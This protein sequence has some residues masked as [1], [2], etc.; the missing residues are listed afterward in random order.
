MKYYAV[1]KGKTPGIYTSWNECKEQIS[2]F[3]DA[4]YKSFSTKKEAEAFVNEKEEELIKDPEAVAYVDGS[5]NQKDQIYGYGGFIIYKKEFPSGGKTETK[6]TLKGKGN[7][8]DML[9][10]RNVSGEILGTQAIV[11]KAIDM[12]IK[13]I[14]IYYDYKGIEMWAKGLWNRNKSGT[15]DYYN[16]MQS[17]KDKII[18]DFVKVKGHTGVA[19]NEEAD[20]LAKEAV[21]IK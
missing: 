2:G 3:P 16:Y 15:I 5:Y 11:K 4:V 18:I 8:K 17:V 1:K 13:S 9:A 20:M 10:M 14:R 21:G 12:G 19:G 6:V 7:N